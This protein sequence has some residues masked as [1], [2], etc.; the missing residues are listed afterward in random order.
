MPSDLAK[1]KAAKKKE[2]AK[3]RQRS[4]KP[5]ELNE[6]AEQLDAQS[7]GAESNGEEEDCTLNAGLWV[8]RPVSLLR[9]ILKL[10]CYTWA[11]HSVK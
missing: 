4:K 8:T 5:D 11:C 7:N 3:A 9:S 2:A 6:E 10:T 1:K